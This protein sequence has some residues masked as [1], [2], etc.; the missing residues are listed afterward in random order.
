MH[1]AVFGKNFDDGF[2]NSIEAFFEIV[3]GFGYKISV[4]RPFYEF[5]IKNCSFELIPDRL[6]ENHFVVEDQVDMMISIGGDGTFLES[7]SFV[8]QLN[9]PIAGIN[10]GRLG[11]LAN[12][13]QVE[14]P[15]AL[16]AIHTGRYT[17]EERTLLEV[18]SGGKAFKNFNYALNE[19]TVQKRDSGSMIV[20]NVKVN[21]EF[22]N[23]YWAD[24]LILATPTG[25]TAY[26]LSLGGPIVVPGSENF[27]LTP[28]APHSL[29]VRPIIIPDHDVIEITVEGRTDNY[30]ASLDHQSEVVEKYT[31]LKVKAADFKLKTVR[32]EGKTFFDTIRDK[33]MWGVD[34]RN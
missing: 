28:I 25:S 17:I 19:L 6:F 12:I 30:L 1:I 32:I 20:V 5:I 2:K 11:F 33:L 29:T 21:G 22:V 18:D 7:V 16:E 3:K 13:S 10:S 24:G 8:G 9:I 23:T 4:Y 26:S 14:I 31:V 34:R 27:I 15:Y